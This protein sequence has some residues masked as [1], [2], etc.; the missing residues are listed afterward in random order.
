[1]GN[2]AVIILACRDYEALELSLACHA[3]YLS[4]N[5]SYF[6]LQNC[7]GC[8]DSERTLEVARRYA[9]LYPRQIFA[10]EDI[11]SGTPYHCISALLERPEFAEIEMICKVDEDVFPLTAGWL[12]ALLQCW[13]EESKQPGPRLAYVTPLVNNNTWG[14]PQV[15][16]AMGLREGFFA[17]V[18]REHRVGFGNEANPFRVLS[19]DE[20]FTG[21]NGTIWGSAYLA[22][23][24]H[25]RTTMVPDEYI[26]AT[27]NLA[28]V[29]VP[30]NE[31]YSI[32]CI[33][34]PKS[35]W[36]EINDGGG[37]DED[38]LHQFCKRET[39]RIVCARNIPFVHMAYFSQR[40]ENRD[41]VEQVRVI[42]EPRLRLP[43]PIAMKASRLLEIE[44]RL[45]WL[46]ANKQKPALRALLQEEIGVHSAEFAVD[47]PA[48]ETQA[49]S[50]SEEL[51]HEIG[52]EEFTAEKSLQINTN[53]DFETFEQPTS[54]P[55]G[56]A[57]MRI[58]FLTFEFPPANGGGLSTYMV[59]ALRMLRRNGDTALVL[60]TD[61]GVR[62]KQASKF[63]GH[64]LIRVNVA[65][66]PIGK[67]MGYWA[68][69]SYV[70]SEALKESIDLYGKP[71]VVE[72]CDGFGL[73]YFTLQRR[74]ALEAPFADLK[75][76]VTAHTPCSLIDHW[77][78]KS[79]YN[80]PR[81]WTRESEIFS[82]KAADAVFAPSQFIIGELRRDFECEDVEFSLVRNPYEGP[83][84]A[85]NSTAEWLSVKDQVVAEEIVSP[86][87]G[88]YTG[89]GQ[90]SSLADPA[91]LNTPYYVFGSRL[92]VWKG[93]LDVVRAFDEYWR[94][95]G[96]ARLKMFGSDTPN[97]GSGTSVGDTIRSRYAARLEAG[98]L[99]LGG[100]ISPEMLAKEK[101]GAVALLHPS[102]KE[103]FPYTVIEH[104]AEGGIV[105][106]SSTGG[107]AELVTHG[108]S[109]WLFAG[110]DVKALQH[111][112]DQCEAMGLDE[113]WAMGDAA[114]ARVEALCSYEAVY[115]SKYEVL[116]SL[117]PQRSSF[118]F[119]RG[120][121]KIFSSKEPNAQS[122]RLS[123]VVS[124]FNLPDYVTETV[125]SA[126]ASTFKDLEIIVVDDGS[127][128]KRSPEVL[129][130][131]AQLE[132]VQVIR[133]TNAGV[134]AARNFGVQKARGEFVALLDADDLVVP[135]YYERCIAILERY[136]N[137]GFVGSWNDDFDESGTLRFW[138]TFNPE[139]PMQ[140]IFNTTNCQGLVMR[141]EAYE[142]AGG[143]DSKL[144]M[145]LDD[146][147][148]TIAMLAKDIRGVMIPMPLFRYR[149]RQ[150]SVFRSKA[151]LWYRNYE[152]IAQKHVDLYRKYA[153]EIIAF[154]NANGPNLNYHNP[155]WAG[156]IGDGT[157]DPFAHG[158]MAR[159]LR[160]YYIFTR[161]T[162]SGRRIRK[163]ISFL[164]PT[165]DG[166][167]RFA[168]WARRYLVR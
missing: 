93:A 137:V 14:F 66:H 46:E 97:A 65:E 35:L 34:F 161:D 109:G 38:M 158:R 111:C 142:L 18:A 128:D 145:F 30:P 104:M 84:S 16:D 148:A 69:A 32:G 63:E 13:T 164:S 155:T 8:Y 73:A 154:L 141:H 117:S 160:G 71:D 138:P 100:L 90:I 3:K 68:A 37:D 76:V 80:L 95:G 61:N 124:Y 77:D 56:K 159:L 75:I 101:R 129:A 22:R 33:L 106:A 125:E 122:P 48:A 127:T 98:L 108:E 112:L 126:L 87:S 85:K 162:R 25:E 99:V 67:S 41:L 115:T 11:D 72:C 152:Y 53:P 88:N 58:A 103:N 70:M 50:N 47:M 12:D 55:N 123:I 28:P 133:Q 165:M 74:A 40:E 135:T 157:A 21:S 131:L 86:K 45:R 44:S 150:G 60:T 31:R 5:I 113:R 89:S 151:D 9:Q 1:M 10:I 167:L 57:K 51:E 64:D 91:V 17:D 24:L 168:H 102:H 132:R 119:I 120:E 134:A 83:I 54:V 39:A 147:E 163:F 27:K 121:Q 130:K 92:S 49:H 78:G 20:I 52:K 15:L 166:A 82:F 114:K 143:H 105:I 19:R 79:W 96:L 136:S 43:F 156:A 94:D 116:K 110:K 139:P 146:W 107:Q 4:S 62:R 140:L 118:P 6:I 42:Y 2:L 59:Q 153:I 7:R 23:W 36:A 29:L 149:I 144:N 26:K 81:Y